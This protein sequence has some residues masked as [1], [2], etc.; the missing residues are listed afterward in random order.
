MQATPQQISA[1]TISPHHQTCR[2]QMKPPWPPICPTTGICITFVFYKYSP[3]LICQTL[4]F[5]C[6]SPEPGSQHC[7]HLFK[8][9]QRLRC[10][11]KQSSKRPIPYPVVSRQGFE[12]GLG[13][14]KQCSGQRSAVYSS[15]GCWL[16]DS[17]ATTFHSLAIWPAGFYF[18]RRRWQSGVYWINS[19]TLEL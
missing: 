4:H 8:K 1:A 18:T 15:P 14:S 10:R 16:R 19:F 7:L 9:I 13:L 17:L 11:D 12:W 2:S 5:T 3:C 6:P